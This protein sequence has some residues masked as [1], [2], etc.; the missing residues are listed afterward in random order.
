[1]ALFVATAI[2]ATAWTTTT[3]MTIAIGRMRLAGSTGTIGS[4]RVIRRIRIE[5]VDCLGGAP[6][7]LIHLVVIVEIQ[8]GSV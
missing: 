7:D 8:V 6:H 3:T 1:M 2:I 5:C 4:V